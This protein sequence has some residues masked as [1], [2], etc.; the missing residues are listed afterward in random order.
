M[1]LQDQMYFFPLPFGEAE[2]NGLIGRCLRKGE[3][4]FLW[5]KLHGRWHLQIQT[6]LTDNVM[7]SYFFKIEFRWPVY[8][9]IAVG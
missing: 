1:Y 6:W 8:S 3:V 4:C 2:F 9:H 7:T 5:Q